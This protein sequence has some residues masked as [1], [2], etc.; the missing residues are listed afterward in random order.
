MHDDYFWKNR[1][2]KAGQRPSATDQAQIYDAL[3]RENTGQGPGMSDRTGASYASP[4][5]D[6]IDLYELTGDMEISAV[7]VYQMW[8]CEGKPVYPYDQTENESDDK[9]YYQ[10]DSGDVAEDLWLPTGFYTGSG[11]DTQARGLDS[12]RTGQRVLT[13]RTYAHRWIISPPL[14][15]WRFELKYALEPGGSATAYLLPWTGAAYVVD[16]DIEFEVYD[17]LK[18]FYG[19][20]RTLEGTIYIPGAYGYAK[21]FPGPNRWEI[22]D[23]NDNVRLFELLAD[24]MPADQASGDTVIGFFLDDPD[25]TEITLYFYER[26]PL[27]IGRNGKTDPS[28]AGTE[29]YATYNYLNERWE[30]VCGNFKTVCEG[31]AVDQIANGATGTIS[32]W[33]MD[34]DNAPALKDSAQDIEALNWASAQVESG[35][36]VIV[37]CDRQENRWTII[38]AENQQP[39]P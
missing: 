17:V 6:Q 27:G 21:Y 12:Y 30:I 14:D 29:G 31:V 3:A 16:T 13:I 32:L 10:V 36:F 34:Y 26:Y 19:R 39:P 9:S 38:E 2:P 4:I 33:W 22:I 8:K 5:A 7:D 18:R 28:Y 37:S 1:R 24:V 11:N 15:I 35:D 20:P 23:M 25:E